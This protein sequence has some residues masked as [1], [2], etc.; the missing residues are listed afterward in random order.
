MGF[1]NEEVASAT[2]GSTLLWWMCCWII[3]RHA[4]STTC[5][6]N[7]WLAYARRAKINQ[8]ICRLVACLALTAVKHGKV[9]PGDRTVQLHRFRNMQVEIRYSHD[10]VFLSLWGERVVCIGLRSGTRGDD[11]WIPSRTIIF[12]TVKRVGL[13]PFPIHDKYCRCIIIA[14]HQRAML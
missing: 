11:G 9:A 3:W 5:R 13:P 7:C 6:I 12:V 1:E 10:L 4:H 14:V 2:V 8:G